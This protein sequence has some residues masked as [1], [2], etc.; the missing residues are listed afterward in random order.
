MELKIEKSLLSSTDG[1]YIQFRGRTNVLLCGVL[2]VWI[3]MK[4]LV[5]LDLVHGNGWFNTMSFT[6]YLGSKHFTSGT[7]YLYT[8]LSKGKSKWNEGTPMTC[9]SHVV[10][11]YSQCQA[12]ELLPLKPLSSVC[13]CFPAG[14]LDCILN[15]LSFE[16]AIGNFRT[17]YY[18]CFDLIPS[19]VCCQSWKSYPV[20][21]NGQC[22]QWRIRNDCV[23]F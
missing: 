8:E 11:M 5:S 13:I 1:F 14:Y 10:V 16:V 23:A 12:A 17:F 9:L 2:P 4:G 20:H 21:C 6:I 7:M 15:R 3:L 22:L 19:P 18:I